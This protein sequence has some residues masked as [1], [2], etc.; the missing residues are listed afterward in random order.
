[1]IFLIRWAQR[2]LPARPALQHFRLLLGGL[3][4]FS[5]A[6]FASAIQVQEPALRF[7]L[8]EGAGTAVLDSSSAKVAGELK[9]SGAGWT[10]DVPA[11]FSSG[12]AYSCDGSRGSRIAIEAEASDAISLLEDFTITCWLNMRDPS[13]L[14]RILSKMDLKHASFFDF[15]LAEAAEGKIKF[16]LALRTGSILD[17]GY[18]QKGFEIVSEDCELPLGWL[19]V[20]VTRDSNS[21]L[22]SFYFGGEDPSTDLVASIGTGDGPKG[23][24]LDN[25]AALMIGNIQVNLG[26]AANADFSDLRIYTEVLSSETI[27][28]VRLQNFKPEP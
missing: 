8:N 13:N 1:M 27:E 16:L 21:G 2:S 9:G 26:R 19:F 17:N 11:A 5:W 23:V 14:R 28:A 4:I 24:I 10:V 18:A 7:A 6:G 25:K 3:I 22:V 20:A 15:R 12:S